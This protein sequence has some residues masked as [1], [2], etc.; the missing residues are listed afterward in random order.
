VVRCG[1]HSFEELRV[2][3]RVTESSGWHESSCEG[4]MGPDQAPV[5]KGA[6]ERRGLGLGL[7]LGQGQ[8]SVRGRM[9]VRVPRLLERG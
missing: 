4:T 6:G 2:E 3:E 8:V 1:R 5:R 7:E 9:R